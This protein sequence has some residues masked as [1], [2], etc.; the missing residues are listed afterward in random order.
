MPAL[1]KHIA[2]PPPIVPAPTMPTLA[3]GRGTTSA[4]SPGIRRT[5]R[6]AKNRCRRARASMACTSCSVFALSTSNP[7]SNGSVTAASTASSSAIGDSRLRIVL[8]T[9]ARA[10]EKIAPAFSASRTGRSRVRRGPAAVRTSS[11]A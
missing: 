8:A 11:P 4:A 3:I 9:L 10:A 1:A 5:S 6:S 2:I 7:W